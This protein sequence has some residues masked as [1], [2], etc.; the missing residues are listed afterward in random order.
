MRIMAPGFDMRIIRYRIV[1]PSFGMRIIRYRIV[2]P[3]FG[4]RIISLV[5][6]CRIKETVIVCLSGEETTHHIHW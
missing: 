3:G 1:T 2:A 6:P 4:T 5:F